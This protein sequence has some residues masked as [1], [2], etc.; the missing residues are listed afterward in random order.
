MT[1][2]LAGTFLPWLRSGAAL[3]NSYQAATALHA[4]V[5][6]VTAALL[7]AWPVVITAWAL[8]VALYALRLRRVAAVV[9]CLFG[10]TTA[11]VA[12]GVLGQGGRSGV[13]V[14]PVT[15]GPAVT[16]IGATLALVGAIGVVA[17]S[18]DRTM[19]RTRGPR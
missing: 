16:L 5:N 18:G 10:L 1:V 3:R 13:L 12:V 14:S 8:C 7:T 6:G 17:G 9:A 11:S 4:W 2:L 15:T 19:V